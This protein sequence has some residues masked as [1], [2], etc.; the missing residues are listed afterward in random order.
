[1]SQYSGQ[2]TV[3]TAG[4]AEQGPATPEVAGNGLFVIR[5]LSGNTNSAYVGNDGAGDVASTNGFELPAGE[6][7]YVRVRKLSDL[8]FDVSTNGDGFSWLLIPG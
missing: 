8:W 7:V 3:T 1:M 4:T 6:M 5:A 2:L